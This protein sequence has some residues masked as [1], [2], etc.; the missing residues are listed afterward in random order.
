MGGKEKRK[1]KAEAEVEV[2]EEDSSDEEVAA[3]EEVTAEAST[4][5][6]VENSLEDPP[7]DSGVWFVLEKASLE[8]AKVGKVG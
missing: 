1:R 7:A 6:Q 4:A 2:P 5:P 3:E 8:A